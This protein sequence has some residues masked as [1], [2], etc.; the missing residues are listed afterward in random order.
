MASAKAKVA[1]LE[2]YEQKFRKQWLLDKKFKKWL[3]RT[4]IN[5][6][7]CKWCRV[8]IHLKLSVIKFHGES[9]RHRNFETGC[10]GAN[11]LSNY[12][13]KGA[14]RNE[15]R[16]A[17]LMITAFLVDHNIPF[18]VMDHL[19]DV[20]SRT[21]PDSAIAREFSCK[22]TKSACLAYDI[23]GEEFKTELINDQRPSISL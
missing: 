7:Y 14:L 17:G 12:F 13:G 20:L 3:D 11:K 6:A 4:T 18:R 10:S 15:T 22:R 5:D 21:F 1:K 19:P 2:S 8:N 16:H 23:L 9:K